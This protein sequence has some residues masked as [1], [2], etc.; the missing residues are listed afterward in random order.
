MNATIL[1][2]FAATTMLAISG[3]P[4]SSPFIDSGPPVGMELPA[5][6]PR[7]V[8]GPDR[9]TTTCPMCKYGMGSGVLVWVNGDDR[10]NV[11]RI[12]A[13]LDRE[14]A[15]RGPDRFRAFVVDMNPDGVSRKEIEQ[16][17]IEL[18]ASQRLHHVALAY[19]PSPTDA[20]SSRL[21][22][23]N[24]NRAVRNTV[25][26]YRRR[27]VTARFVNLEATPAGVRPLLQAIASVSGSESAR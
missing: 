26:V 10:D 7:H 5:F 17:L 15:R 22:R 1:A 18:E 4:L 2:L 16:R 12:A 24:P 20:K 3:N 9:G 8:T 11:V 27:R 23:I 19:V 13:A 14:I 25:L 21:Y 6:D